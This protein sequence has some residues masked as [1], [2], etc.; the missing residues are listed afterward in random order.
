MSRSATDAVTQPGMLDGY[1]PRPG[2]FDEM[3]GPDG[4][5]RPH[6]R[7]LM[8]GLADMG[9]DLLAERWRSA[10]RQIVENAAIYNAFAEGEAR[11][12]PWQLD[13]VPLVLSAEEWRHIAGGLQQ[14]ARLINAILNDLYGAQR[15]LHEGLVPSALLFANPHFLRPCHGT[16]LPSDVWLH[17]LA[18]DLGRGSDG[19]WRV[20]S[21][22][23][24]TP[25]GAGFA[26]E[27]RIIVSRGL[28]ELFRGEHVH[29][30]ADDHAHA[31]LPAEACGVDPAVV[32]TNI[33][34]VPRADAADFVSAAR[35]AGVAVATVG[36]RTVRLVTHLDISREDAQQ[37]AAVLARLV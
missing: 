21:D 11:D 29:R 28:P 30:L 14:R 36:P 23:T 5:V 37:A 9:P 22:R 16:R 6:W 24:Q 33:V 4:Q 3:L 19:R 35:E 32:D 12:R 10:E 15:I 25:T 31:R 20:L 26:L 2:G 7:R 1:A 18:C 17:L 27:N 34:V 8:A 13:P